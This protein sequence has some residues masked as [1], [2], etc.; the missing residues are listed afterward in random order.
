MIHVRPYRAEDGPACEAVFARAVG[1][2]ATEFY[3]AAQRAAWMNAPHRVSGAMAAKLAQDLC[4]VSEAKGQ[5]TGFLSMTA[6]G[7]L[8]MAYVL[9]EAM[10]K[11]HAAAL[12]DAMLAHARHLGL[13]RLDV[14]ASEYSR[15]FLE[16]RGWRHDRVEV[17]H[18]QG[19]VTLDRNHM[20]LDLT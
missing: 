14:H 16:R 8:D 17:L 7:H 15:R 9:P 11:G 4:W 3:S 6:Q 12:Y 2:G 18:R 13:K 1:E 20:S 10:G 5:I 19:G